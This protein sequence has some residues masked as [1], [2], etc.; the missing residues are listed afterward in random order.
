MNKKSNRSKKPKHQ[1]S[2]AAMDFIF[3]VVEAGLRKTAS[4]LGRTYNEMNV[5]VYYGIIPLTWV[6][7]LD[8]IL[9]IH[10]F[11]FGFICFVLG[12]ISSCGH[13]TLYCDRVFAKS[14]DFLLAFNRIGSNYTSASVWVCVAAPIAVYGILGL[15]SLSEIRWIH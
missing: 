6:L 3:W 2:S 13:F 8:Y 9:S 1:A 12:V 15:L 4:L 14:V 10:W 5:I 7:M 11:T